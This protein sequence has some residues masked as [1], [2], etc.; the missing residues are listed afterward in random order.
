MKMAANDNPCIAEEG[1]TNAQA[2]ETIDQKPQRCL[3]WIRQGQV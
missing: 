3:T 2:S 1:G